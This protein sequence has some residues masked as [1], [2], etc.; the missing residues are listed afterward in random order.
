MA[1]TFSQSIDG[2]S[3]DNAQQPKNINIPDANC[4]SAG[5]EQNAMQ[6]GTAFL[7]Q[8]PDGSSVLCVYDTERCIPGVQRV[9]RK[10]Y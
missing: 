5:A 10:L 1:V 9:L 7:A 8:F 6:T 2:A 3:A 4:I